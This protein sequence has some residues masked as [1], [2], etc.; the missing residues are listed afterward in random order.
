[1]AVKMDRVNRGRS[2]TLSVG[3]AVYEVA[4]YNEIDPLAGRVV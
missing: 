1:M 4:G 3:A 2:D